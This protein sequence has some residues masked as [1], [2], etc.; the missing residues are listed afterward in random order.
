MG[1][2]LTSSLT[3]E[4]LED[5]EDDEAFEL[6]V[7]PII[8]WIPHAS[9]KLLIVQ[10][11]NY[12]NWKVFIY[13][14]EKILIT[15]I[16]SYDLWACKKYPKIRSMTFQLCRKLFGSIAFKYSEDARLLTPTYSHIA[17]LLDSF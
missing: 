17:D 13:L 12:L 1:S 8:I 11:S 7:V 5:D 4:L 15:L 2:D 9:Q 6:K 10:L 3:G 16:L 14:H